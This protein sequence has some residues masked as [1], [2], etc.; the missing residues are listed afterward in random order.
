MDFRCKISALK[1]EIIVEQLLRIHDPDG[2]WLDSEMLLQ[3][4]ETILSFVLQN[5]V[6]SL[7]HLRFNSTINLSRCFTVTMTVPIKFQV[8]KPSLAENIMT[9][10]EFFESTETLPYAISR[11]SVQV[12]R[13]SSFLSKS[14]LP[15]TGNP[16]S[17]E[18]ADVLSMQGGN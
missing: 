15:K 13:S 4:V 10:I 6:S 9:N 16:E 3:E 14:I 18:V 8:S 2:R 7:H 11:I 12:N 1:E 5:D 17:L